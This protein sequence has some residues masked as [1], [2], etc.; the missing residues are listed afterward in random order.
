MRRM[1]TSGCRSPGANLARYMQQGEG[2]PTGRQR[3]DRHPVR[4]RFAK[5]PKLGKDVC[6]AH[7][8]EKAEIRARNAPTG[9]VTVHSPGTVEIQ[10][11]GRAPGDSHG[12]EGRE[13]GAGGGC[14]PL[15]A[16]RPLGASSLDN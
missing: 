8:L 3:A 13:G 5:P 16:T 15:E 10:N 6:W 12:R 2:N 11:Q 9:E 7:G 14:E 4:G 1:A